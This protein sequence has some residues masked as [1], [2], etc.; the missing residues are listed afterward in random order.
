MPIPLPDS[1]PTAYT[2]P[3]RHCAMSALFIAGLT[4]WCAPAKPQDA[5]PPPIPQERRPLF[6]VRAV[7]RAR[8]VWKCPPHFSIQCPPPDPVALSISTP[9]SAHLSGVPVHSPI[10]TYF[11]SVAHSTAAVRHVT[12]LCDVSLWI[13]SICKHLC[14]SPLSS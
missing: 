3:T 14:C 4:R 8:A 2:C 7:S 6:Q 13:G 12:S 5:G 9:C 10:T 11:T 1:S